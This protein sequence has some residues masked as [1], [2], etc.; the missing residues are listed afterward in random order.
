MYD[1]VVVGGNLAGTTAAINAAKEGT[2]VALIERNKKPFFPAHCGEMLTDVETRLLE[3]DRIGCDKNKINKIIINISSK[4]YNFKLR[5]IK[6][7]IFNRNFLEK[8]LLR[9]A[10]KNGVKLIIGTRM[11]DYKPPNEIYLDNNEIIK[12]KIIIDSSGITCHVGKRIGIDTKLKPGDIGVCIQ[13]RVQGNF[14]SNKIKSWFHKPYAP[15]GYAWIFPLDDKTANIG[16]GVAG[17]QKL[18]LSKL[19]N[20]YITDEI[21]GKYKITHTFRSCV[22]SAPPMS[23]LI[24]DNVIITGDAA[25]LAHSLSGGGIRNALF[26]GSLAGITAAK[27]VKGEISSL[28]PY[29][30]F[31]NTKISRLQKEYNF[32]NKAFKNENSLLT[33]F[34]SAISIACSI[35]KLFPNVFE[36]LYKKFSENDK[37]ILESYKGSTFNLFS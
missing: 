5:T 7:I 27:Y 35:N 2:N 3:L 20:K 10:E 15:F 21:K 24:K 33:K 34:G 36:V 4:E 8:R 9:E 29:Q 25:R 26:S 23:K 17:G 6:I 22:P 14:D 11:R 30:D 37:L 16:L 13:S 31:M 28:E 12:G 1:V 32:K 18:D 19:L